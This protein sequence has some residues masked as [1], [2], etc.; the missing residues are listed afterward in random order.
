MQQ[1]NN[2]TKKY[3]GIDWGLSRIGLALGDDE[4]NMAIPFKIVSNVRDILKIIKEEEIDIIVLG[5]PIKMSGA[6]DLDDNFLKFKN[7]F[8]KNINIPLKYIDERLTSKAA[9]ALSGDKKNKASR[10]ALAA[11]LILQSYFDKLKNEGN[12]QS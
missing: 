1:P 6:N 4:T 12:I 8:E 3:L 7:K 5:E 10:D 9:D 2:E 11:M